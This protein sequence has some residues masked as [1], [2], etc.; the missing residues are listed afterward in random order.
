ML[1]QELLAQAE[2]K[3]SACFA[4]RWDDFAGGQWMLASIFGVIR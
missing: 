3:D 2:S 4:A 1:N